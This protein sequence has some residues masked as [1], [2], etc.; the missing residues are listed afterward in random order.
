M[1]FA[2][3]PPLCKGRWGAAPEG[4]VCHPTAGCNGILPESPSF[5][6]QKEAKSSAV[7]MRRPP[8][9]AA[10]LDPGMRPPYDGL[11]TGWG[12]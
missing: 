12:R 3:A 7:S 10:A 4:L 1:L 9:R 2:C 8:T 11:L 6:N 5:C